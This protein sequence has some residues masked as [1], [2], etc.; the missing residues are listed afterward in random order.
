M[1]IHPFQALRC[2]PQ[3]AQR[4]ASVPY[5]VVDFREAAALAEGNPLSF[6]R[7]V[8][9]EIELPAGTDPHDDAV[10]QRAAANFEALQRDGHLVREP[11]P[12]LFAYRMTAGKHVQTGLLACCS[13]DEYEQGIIKKHE[14]TRRDKEDDRTRHMLALRAQ[15]GPVL[16]AY[17]DH[18]AIDARLAAAAAGPPLLRSQS[19]TGVVHEV[20]RI[21]R[22]AELVEAFAAIPAAYIADGHHRIASACRARAALRQDNPRHD[23]REEYNFFLA[24]LFPASQMRILAYNRTVRD[25]GGHAAAQ[26][27]ERLNAAFEVAA[28]GQDTPTAPRQFCMYLQDRWYTLTIRPHLV[29]ERDPVGALDCSL[30]HTHL[31]EPIL[32]ITDVRGDPRIGFA[33]GS[34][35]TQALS[36]QVRSGQAAVAFSLYPTSM[37]QLIAV[38]DAGRIMPPKST[39]FE[40][41]LRSGLVVH[42]I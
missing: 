21:E 29:D 41:K 32:G 25:L 23:G 12:C 4:L 30:L 20:W 11:Q 42:P 13:I 36:E 9:A 10:Y 14:L 3:A 35:G 7:V 19:E 22:H 16:V 5:D 15:P 8:R 17:P 6:L 34:R 1:I 18:A 37:D 27:L 31:I 33:G 38:A 26:F 40:P 2:T 24:A 39:W 28:S